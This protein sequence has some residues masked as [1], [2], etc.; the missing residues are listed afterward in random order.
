[1]NFLKLIGALFAAFSLTIGC[2]KEISRQDQPSQGTF[3]QD[4]AGNCLPFIVGGTYRETTILNATNYIEIQLN[5]TDPGSYNI[6]SDTV[7]GYSFSATGFIDV[8][9]IH[10]VRLIANGTPV[11]AGD[12]N[13][14]I[15]YNGVINPTTCTVEIAVLAINTPAVYIFGTTGSACAGAIISGTYTAGTSV[16]VSNTVSVSVNVSVTGSY[17]ITTSNVNGLTFAASGDF[18]TT[19]PQNVTLLASGTPAAAGI[20]NYNLIGNSTSCSFSLTVVGGLNGAIF[21]LAGA[22]GTCTNFDGSGN[23]IVGT[24]LSAAHTITIHVN[25]T[26]TGAYNISTPVVNGVTFSGAGTFNTTGPQTLLL[27]GAGTPIAVGPA[28]HPVTVGVNTCTF[29]IG[30]QPLNP[31]PPIGQA[32]YTFSGQPGFCT[33]AVVAGSYIVGTPLNSSNTVT[34]EVNV[35]TVG[36][37]MIASLSP[38]STN[39][40]SFIKTGTFTTTGIQNVVFPGAGIPT[41]VGIHQFSPS[42]PGVAGCYFFIKS[43]AT[44][45]SDFMV[46]QIENES[47]TFDVQ[48]GASY[49]IPMTKLLMKGLSI[50]GSAESLS[51]EIDGSASGETITSKAYNGSSSS[52]PFKISAVYVDNTGA[53]W[54]TSDGSV[55]PVDV[56]LLIITSITATRVEGMFRTRVR[57]NGGNGPLSKIV[58]DG[59]FS[60]PIQ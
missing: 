53:I 42:A 48:A 15:N 17:A 23:Y 49:L 35:T 7:N 13:F 1:M 36:T 22:G 55:N 34:V 43:T 59:S 25:V 14:T 30:Y 51:L 5:I 31:P 28:F 29:G 52:T 8:P 33:P 10:T 12:N 60:I 6:F 4:T 9:G 11:A 21:T 16:G 40:M 50:T 3:Q 56:T 24:P 32:V 39:G 27:Q 46:A 44:V 58:Q 2:Q 19:G 54:K 26:A 37:Y 41:K 18:T 20:T 57:N 47:K 38:F 45:P